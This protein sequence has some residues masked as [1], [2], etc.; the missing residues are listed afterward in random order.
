MQ[1]AIKG[2]LCYD[3]SGKAAQSGEGRPSHSLECQE[4]ACPPERGAAHGYIF[5][6]DSDRHINCR[7]LQSGCHIDPDGQKEMTAGHPHTVRRS[8]R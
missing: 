8:F 2:H 6:F 1:L 5:R 3:K 4:G 7:H